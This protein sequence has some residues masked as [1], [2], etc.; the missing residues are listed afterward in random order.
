MR[1]D[2]AGS[3]KY[4]YTHSWDTEPVRLFNLK[5]DLHEQ[6]NL[7]AAFPDVTGRLMRKIEAW[8]QPTVSRR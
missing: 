7:S 1:Y 3:T 8:Y 2:G 5:E 6:Q 4:K